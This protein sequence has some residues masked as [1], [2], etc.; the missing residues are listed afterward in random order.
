MVI[1]EKKKMKNDIWLKLK[2]AEYAFS[3]QQN[4]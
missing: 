2:Y 3:H 1:F 4:S